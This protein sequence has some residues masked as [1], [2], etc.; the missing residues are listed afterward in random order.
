MKWQDE[1]SYSRE[2]RAQGVPPRNWEI[3]VEDMRLAVHRL[4]KLP[5]WYS[6]CRE[7]DIRDSPIMGGREVSAEIAQRVALLEASVRAVVLMNILRN[8]LVGAA[9]VA[10]ECKIPADHMLDALSYVLG[11]KK[12]L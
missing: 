8:F 5:G 10:K 9:E 3:K 12:S 11:N 7:L 6:T 4:H 2:E 1:T